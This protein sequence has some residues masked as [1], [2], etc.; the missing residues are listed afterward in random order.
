MKRDLT[1][2]ELVAVVQRI[3]DADG[4]GEDLQD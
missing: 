2:Q 1:K 3:M 4:T